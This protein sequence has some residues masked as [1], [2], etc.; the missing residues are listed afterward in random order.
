[1]QESDAR[2]PSGA[3]RLHV[4][5]PGCRKDTSKMMGPRTDGGTGNFR[6]P[7]HRD[8]RRR[9]S[10]SGSTASGSAGWSRT[11]GSASG[12][13]LG[14]HGI[15]L[16]SGGPARARPG[17]D[18]SKCSRRREAGTPTASAYFSVITGGLTDDGLADDGPGLEVGFDV[19][20]LEVAGYANN[21]VSAPKT[22]IHFLSSSSSTLLFICWN[23]GILE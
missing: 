23:I 19:F 3:L 5:D 18:K 10:G 11:T 12:I 13:Q 14:F 17:C 6:V 16:A 1:M 22:F 7:R 2:H 15:G 9:G 21:P 4:F 8:P 20:G